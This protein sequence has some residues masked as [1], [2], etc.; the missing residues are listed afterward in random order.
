MDQTS[1]FPVAHV[2]PPVDVADYQ[3]RRTATGITLRDYQ[4]ETV[5]KVLDAERRGVRRQLIV[6]PTAGGKTLIFSEIAYTKLPGRTLILSHREELV[7]QAG[8]K[9]SMVSGGLPVGIVRAERNDDHFAV[10]SASVPTLRGARL[11]RFRRDWDFVVIDEAHHAAA[12]TYRRIIEHLDAGSATGPLLLGVTATADR[13][14]KQGLDDIFDEIVQEIKLPKLVKAGYIADMR[15]VRVKIGLNLD[16]VKQSRGDYQDGDLGRAMHDIGAADKIAQAMIVHA[17]GRKSL[18]FTPTIA[19]AFELA[20][21]CNRGNI[22][23]EVVTGETPQDERRRIVTALRDGAIDAIA[24]CAVF[25]EG[26]DIPIVDCIVIARPTKSRSLYAQM[27]GRGF[28]TY[29]GKTDCLVMDIVGVSASHKLVTLATLLG[30]KKMDGQESIF[31]D[32]GDMVQEGTLGMG[33]LEVL[34]A[35]D[36]LIQGATAAE[37]FDAMGNSWAEW[38]T[39]PNNRGFELPAGD[40]SFRIVPYRGVDPVTNQDLTGLYKVV[41]KY[42]GSPNV[43]VLADRLDLGYAQGVTERE[44]ESA[45]HL[46]AKNARWKNDPLTPGQMRVLRNAGIDP[47]EVKT[48]GEASRIISRLSAGARW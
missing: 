10:V 14:D 31:N 2:A 12:P 15:G 32:R 17:K 1:L 21:A 3:A 28:R 9:F 48:K 8:E 42:R 45:R 38:I 11:D 40:R 7:E 25:T 41:F 5:Q 34:R 29:P 39:L 22:R 27:C 18:I 43:E 13:G 16:T 26:T 6:V 37:S 19:T 35:T 36:S 44:A 4:V 23:C 30:S 24:N 47:D 20:E 33:L 46:V